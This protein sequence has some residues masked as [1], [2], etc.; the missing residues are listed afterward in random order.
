[1]TRLLNPNAAIALL[2]FVVVTL[3]VL[4]ASP[5]RVLLLIGGLAAFMVGL[6]RWNWDWMSKGRLAA[7]MTPEQRAKQWVFL[8]MVVVL[9]HVIPIDSIRVEG[10]SYWWESYISGMLWAPVYALAAAIVWRL[11]PKERIGWRGWTVV[12]VLLAASMTIPAG[13]GLRDWTLV[14]LR[15]VE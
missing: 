13:L 3:G 12:G 9:V 5:W 7:S 8:P 14:T 2:G 15:L 1:M 10:V 6:I 4:I 11:C